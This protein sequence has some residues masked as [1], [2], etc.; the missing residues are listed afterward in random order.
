MKKIIIGI[1]CLCFVYPVFSEGIQN[2]DSRI[3]AIDD[4]ISKLM[5]ERKNLEQMKG[6]VIKSEKKI[7]ANKKIKTGSQKEKRPKIALVL[8]GGG[9]KGAA[10]VGV[11]KV[12]EKH[13]VPV[14]Y[15]VGTSIGSIVGG[16]YSVGYNPD[17]IENVLLNLNFTE[18]LSRQNNRRGR[19][20]SEKIEQEMYPFT[21]NI[22]KQTGITLPQGLWSNQNIYFELKEIFSRA[23]KIDNFDELPIKF[24]AVAA[25]LQDGS[26]VVLS[27]GDM[28]LNVLKSMSLPSIF[29]PVEDEGKFYIDGGVVNN[30][31]VNTALS[32]GADIIIA[33]DITTDPLVIDEKSNIFTIMSQISTYQGDKNTELQRKLASLLIVPDVKDHNMIDFSNMKPLIGEGEKAASKYESQI[34]SLSNPEA[35]DN[36]RRSALKEEPILIKNIILS[37]ND[38]LTLKKVMALKPSKGSSLTKSEL[39]NWAKQIHSVTY[40]EKVNYHVANNTLYLDVKE[41]KD[42]NIKASLG[43]SSNYGGSLNI[44]ANIPNYGTFSKNYMIRGEMSKYPKLNIGGVYYYDFNKYKIGAIV[45]AGYEIDPLFVYNKG[46][47]V[48][49]YTSDKFKGS[50][51]F[52]TTIFNDII[53]G[54]KFVYERE[55]NRYDSGTRDSSYF[56]KTRNELSGGGYLLFDKLDNKIFPTKGMRLYGEWMKYGSDYD[57]FTVSGTG[58]V[59][60]NKRLALN[61]GGSY[62]EIKGDK[63]G[64]EKLFKIGGMQNSMK[65][66]SFFGLPPMGIYTDKYYIGHVGVQ[67]KL[68]DSIYLLGKYN[69]LAYESNDVKYQK[70]RKLND[71][72]VHGYGVGVGVSTFAGPISFFVSN[73]KNKKN[74]VLFEAR[75]GYFFN[76]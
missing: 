54:P 56:S 2:V 13:K 33:V 23:E 27:K 50:L 19:E 75:I 15:I 68:T 4:E 32:M 6:N 48:S 42:F 25:N 29:E 26:E 5:E 20:I 30:F 37:G 1:I 76:N 70:N 66:V 65:N 3:K 73:N 45:D 53:A 57:I 41:K 39:N 38:A 28:A 71:H 55:K 60:I 18:L 40:I 12:L 31:P 9:A 47:N 74:S 21:L 35:F 10:H 58:A 34:K 64:R 49:T 63:P 11:L 8:S 62:G 14:D 43:Y 51:V 16:M 46:D 24:R 69:L 36:I 17:E 67:Y 52:F 59:P 61:F 7:K 72:Y 22:D 44:L